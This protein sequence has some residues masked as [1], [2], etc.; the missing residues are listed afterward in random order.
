MFEMGGMMWDG[1]RKAVYG[2][3]MSFC[4]VEVWQSMVQFGTVWGCSVSVVR[5]FYC[6]SEKEP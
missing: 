3:R 2:L 6:K 1:A 5:W 4:M